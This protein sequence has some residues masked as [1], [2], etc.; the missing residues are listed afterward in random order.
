MVDSLPDLLLIIVVLLAVGQIGLA[1]FLW[2]SEKEFLAELARML[3]IPEQKKRMWGFWHQ[4][5][6]KAQAVLGEA[7]IEGVKVVADT[8]YY[9]QKLEGVYEDQMRQATARMETEFKRVI[10]VAQL[11]FGKSLAEL[12][13]QSKKIVDDAM[14]AFTKRLEERLAEVEQTTLKLGFEEAEKAKGEVAEYKKAMLEKVRADMTAVLDEVAKE[15][16]GKK[17]VV[18]D[19]VELINEALEK[20]KKEKFI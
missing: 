10:D 19:Q 3:G 14:I 15:V 7:E 13:E 2:R 5:L 16:L 9:T 12:G 18:E 1:V 6:K 17:L 8:K 4:A 20:A 11:E